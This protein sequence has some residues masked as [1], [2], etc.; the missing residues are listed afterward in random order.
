M[1]QHKTVGRFRPAEVILTKELHDHTDKNTCHIQLIWSS[2]EVYIEG[3]VME[4]SAKK[5]IIYG[6]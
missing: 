4:S 3:T 6:T 5:R 1:M 2:P